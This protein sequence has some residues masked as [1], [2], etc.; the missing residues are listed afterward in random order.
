MDDK[1]FERLKE[2]AMKEFG[3]TLTNVDYTKKSNMKATKRPFGELKLM[4]MIN[5]LRERGASKYDIEA[6]IEY[7]NKSLSVYDP[8]C[9]GYRT[10]ELEDALRHWA[11]F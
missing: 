2:V 7:R 10:E 6:E 11:E 9:F 1:V 4:A 3:V 8:K 5:N